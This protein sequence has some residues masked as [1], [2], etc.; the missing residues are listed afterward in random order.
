MKRSL[1]EGKGV[2]EWGR[3]SLAKVLCLPPRFQRP[4]LAEPID[5]P[6]QAPSFYEENVMLV[7][8]NYM[9]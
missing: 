8:A 3:P 5:L 7:K 1:E 2:G 4:T 6:K 9:L